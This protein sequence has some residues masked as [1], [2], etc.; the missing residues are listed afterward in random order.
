VIRRR[1]AILV[2]LALLLTSS[3]ASAR[4]SVAT[5]TAAELQSAVETLTAT[6]MNG[7]RTGTTGGDRATA[8][9]AA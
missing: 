6:E 8:K 5:P 4:S 9:L 1:A 3:V 2:A 7:R